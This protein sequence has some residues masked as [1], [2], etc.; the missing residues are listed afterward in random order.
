[1]DAELFNRIT[2]HPAEFRKVLLIDTDDGPRRYA[3]VM[4]D[5]Q[6]RDFDALDPGW[7]AVAEGRAPEFASVSLR[8]YL[9]RPR[10][11]D[12]TNSIAVMA[13]W[14]LLSARRPV[15]GVVAAADQDQARLIRDAIAKLVALSTWLGTFLTVQRNAIL[16]EHIGSRLDILTSDA[17]SSY[18]L[19]PDFIICD[20]LTHWQSEELWVSLLSAAA[21]RRNCMLAIISNAGIGKGK[22]W[23]WL[24]REGFRTGEN[25]YFSRLEGP[26]ASWITP[27]RLAEQER[28][29]PPLAY[30]RLWLNEWTT[31]AGD[32][33]TEADIQA[34][35]VLDG[36]MY[37]YE[38]GHSFV[39]AFDL[40]I[41]RDHSAFI[42]LACDHATHK[43]KLARCESWRPPDGGEVQIGNVF[44][45]IMLARRDFGMKGVLYDPWQGEYLAQSLREHGL[46]ADPMPFIGQ[47]LN[48]MATT[49]LECFRSRRI[50]LYDEP[51]LLDDLRN[52]TVEEKPYGFRLQAARTAE[53]GHGDRATALAIG[54][55]KATEVAALPLQSPIDDGLG[56]NLLRAIGADI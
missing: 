24:V 10:G 4:D 11:H 44:D 17:P 15:S 45:A 5:W 25:T 6:R 31:G 43:I 40:G 54:L 19:T 23:Q 21:K 27:A 42:V 20:E 34:A 32:A 47:N 37:C 7:I 1:M 22:F 38:D 29:L 55:P 12:K 16:N 33:L 53:G 51:E 2:S 26:V 35:L 30:R 18:G 3:D 13:I 56:D 50:A 49:V 46:M 28:L 52:L 41:K 48:L 8:A 14:V 39:G 9:E 36:P